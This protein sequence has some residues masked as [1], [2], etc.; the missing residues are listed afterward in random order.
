MSNNDAFEDLARFAMERAV[1]YRQ[2][3]DSISVRPGPVAGPENIT[4]VCYF[5]THGYCGYRA[6]GR[7][8]C[9]CLAYG[10]EHLEMQLVNAKS[11]F[12]NH[13]R[14]TPS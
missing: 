11:T 5:A 14:R 9:A 4:R 6:F 2:Q 10:K 12:E 7:I 13:L 8:D 1:A 3:S